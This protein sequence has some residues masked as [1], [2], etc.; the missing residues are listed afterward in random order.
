[1]NPT[2]L[3][4]RNGRIQEAAKLL[5]KKFRRETGCIL[6]EG[7]RLVADAIDAGVE[8]EE[9]FCTAE[10][11]AAHAGPEWKWQ[12][13]ECTLIS[14]PTAVKLSDTQTPQG[15]FAVARFALPTL[16]R[17]TL[18]PMALVIVA[19]GIADPGNLGTIIRSAAA[20][21]QSPVLLTGATCEALNPKVVRAT[22]GAIFRVPVV[23]AGPLAGVIPQLKERGLQVV[24]AVA[25]EGVPPCDL[26]L[27]R[28][29]ALLIGS[30]AEGLSQDAVAAAD[31]LAT[32]PMASVESL[33]AA[34]AATV[35]L[36]EAARQQGPM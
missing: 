8:I 22:M 14:D 28:P 2:E 32:I 17:L 29:T 18:G 36:Y 7:A 4:P 10:F 16:D 21:R 20:I 27:R 3:T 35:F 6:L 31:A 30:E 19:D 1:M 24:A 13:R 26:D 25:R 5:Q 33:N 9:V 34:T 12:G 23:E 11:V 15:I